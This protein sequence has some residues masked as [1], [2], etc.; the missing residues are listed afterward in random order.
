[1]IEASLLHA[2]ETGQVALI[3]ATCNQVNQDGGYTGITPVGFRSEVES[4]AAKVGFPVDRILLGGDHLGPHPWSSEGAEKAMVKA[5]EMVRLY[6]SAGFTKIHLDASMPCAGETSPLPD[7]VIAERAARLCAA[8]Q[9]ARDGRDLRYIIG[10]EVPTPGGALEEEAHLTVTSPAAAVHA[11]E[12]H[13]EAFR[14]A[15][16]DEAWPRVIGLVVQPGVEF[17]NDHIDDYVTEKAVD[18]I[19]L[20]AAY[21]GLVYEAHSTD[22]Q[23]TETFKALVAGGFRILKVGPALTYAMRQAL[24]ALEAIEVELISAE[25]CSR[26]RETME[27]IMLE[28]P[29]YWKSHYHGSEHDLKLQRVHSYSDRIRYYWNQPEAQSAVDTLI[30]NL[31]SV[32]IPETLLS[33]YLPQQYLRVRSGEIAAQ[34]LPLIFDAVREALRPYSDATA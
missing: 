18:L 16:L 22:Y 25:R 10:T 7:E 33:D 9:S 8:A 30:G 15:G 6:V 17:A 26:L 1:V 28:R 34:P 21:P 2:L 14:R 19:K 31:S 11:I 3:E 32:T 4:I 13:R 27:R 12:T 24:F 29:K 5:E 20:L 23:R